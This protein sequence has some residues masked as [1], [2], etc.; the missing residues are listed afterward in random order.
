MQDVRRFFGFAAEMPI[1]AL[2]TA[3]PALVE[4][5]GADG[6]PAISLA[7]HHHADTPETAADRQ[8]LRPPGLVVAY[9][10]HVDNRCEVARAL[11]QS[12]LGVASDGTVIAAAYR[13]WGERAAAH[14]IGEFAF[15][16]VDGSRRRIVAGQDALGVRRLYYRAD[17]H[18]VWIASNLSLLFSRF[19][20][21]DSEPDPEVMPEYFS[22]PMLPWR[23][24]TILTGFRQLRHGTSLV[25]TAAGVAETQVWAPQ[26]PPELRRL[27]PAEVQSEFRRLVFEAVGHALRSPGPVLCD[28]SGGLDSTTICAAASIASESSRTPPILTWST[29]HAAATDGRIQR[30]VRDHLGIESITLAIEDHL[31]FSVLGD[32]ELPD[33]SFVQCAA[34]DRVMRSLCTARGISTRLTGH[35]LDNLLQKGCPVPVYL[36]DYLRAWR[37]SDWARAF[38]AHLAA[39]TCSGWQLLTECSTGSLDLHAGRHRQ[40][41][42]SWLTPRF[43]RRVEQARAEFL[44]RPRVLASRARDRDYQATLWMLPCNGHMLSDERKPLAYRPLV[45]FL[46]GVE[47]SHLRQPGQDRPLLRR[48]FADLLPP[49]VRAEAADS[50]HSA[51]VLDGLQRGWPQLRSLMTGHCLADLGV[52]EPGPWRLAVDRARAGY[53]G[54]DVQFLNTTL[55]LEPWLATRARSRRDRVTIGELDTQARRMSGC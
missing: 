43:R 39:G 37:W 55:Y 14:L 16:V 21:A 2:S 46:L 5:R 15:L 49:A 11:G 33:S 36:H 26:P 28:L 24:R 44:H 22:G 52:L 34:A 13:A 51:S 47:W 50:R 29:A 19:P 53:L 8:P 18:H 38:K 25:V 6:H 7:V 40:P 4:T 23:G 27:G 41:L 31:P 3:F 9:E 17:A 42:P 32:A 20:R 45:E 35:G 10:G 30:A 1:G 54:V 12:D 48:A